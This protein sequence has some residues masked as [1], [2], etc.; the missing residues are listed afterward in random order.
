M[1]DTQEL[2]LWYGLVAALRDDA[3][4][5][6]LIGDRIYDEPPQGVTRPY[7]RL[8]NYDPSPVRSDCGTAIEITFSIEVH[9]RPI[10]AGRTEAMRIASAVVAA[11]SDN[12]ASVSVS[13]YNLIRLQWMPG[14]ATGGRDDDGESHTEI[15]GFEALVDY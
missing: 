12:E 10:A 4:V 8:G 14:A 6:A 9:S 2:A 11:L 3:V 15:R 7:V 13:R 5:G 1:V